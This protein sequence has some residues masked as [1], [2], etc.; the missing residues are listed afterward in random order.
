MLKK[1]VVIDHIDSA[2]V[3]R[4]NRP[5]NFNALDVDVL[6]EITDLVARAAVDDNTAALIITG[7]G[8]SFCS[9]GDLS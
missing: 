7:T 4:I 5:D 6:K 3:I 8:R 9:G 1:S 2:A